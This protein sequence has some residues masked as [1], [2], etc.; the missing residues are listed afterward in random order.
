MSFRVVKMLFKLIAFHHCMFASKT[1]TSQN[2]AN[3]MLESVVE[4]LSVNDR[5]GYAINVSFR[6]NSFSF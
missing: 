5:E 1:N 4:S 2:I 6:K 3:D